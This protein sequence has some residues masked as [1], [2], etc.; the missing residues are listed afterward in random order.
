MNK[1]TM[2]TPGPWSAV[3]HTSGSKGDYQVHS[4]GASSMVAILWASDRH[5]N[6]EADARLMAAADDLLR[7]LKKLEWST[8]GVGFGGT[9][10]MCYGHPTLTGHNDGCSLHAAI[11]KASS[12]AEK[13]VE[14]EPFIFIAG[15]E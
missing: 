4:H 8:N 3:R 5:P 9:C 12:R 13:V 7:E 11:I 14:P 2:N 15:G 1:P 6:R 10:P